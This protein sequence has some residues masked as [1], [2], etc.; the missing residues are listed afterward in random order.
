MKQRQFKQVVLLIL[1]AFLLW[2]VRHNPA[3]KPYERIIRFA[4]LALYVY[5]VYVVVVWSLSCS[6]VSMCCMRVPCS[7]RW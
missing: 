5:L 2:H 4:S 3:S 1:S 6:A 7:G